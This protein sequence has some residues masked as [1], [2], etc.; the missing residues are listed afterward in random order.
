MSLRGRSWFSPEAISDVGGDCFAAHEQ[1]RRLATTS[2]DKMYGRE[3]VVIDI[4]DC[5]GRN[6][7]I[8]F[9]TCFGVSLMKPRL[10]L[11]VD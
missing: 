1:D 4:D 5:F 7:E 6:R 10:Y 3:F 8:I 2:D 9:K 11:V